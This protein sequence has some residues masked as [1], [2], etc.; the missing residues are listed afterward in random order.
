M[1]IICA[2]IQNWWLVKIRY[3]VLYSIEL[4]IYSIK[5]WK[6]SHLNIVIVKRFFHFHFFLIKWFVG[7]AFYWKLYSRYCCANVF[8]RLYCHTYQGWLQRKKNLL[9]LTCLYAI[10]LN[11]SPPTP[12]TH[13]NIFW[14]PL[15][16]IKI[17]DI[18]SLPNNECFTKTSY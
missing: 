14:I 17:Y 1:K 5:F 2:K 13:Q 9:L 16:P 8:N 4:F 10:L 7:Y 18:F 12:S 6:E 11:K 3:Q 15:F